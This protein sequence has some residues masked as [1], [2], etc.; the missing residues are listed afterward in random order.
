MEVVGFASAVAVI[1][2][3]VEAVKRAGFPARFAAL[4]A[5]A[6]GAGGGAALKP[7]NDLRSKAVIVAGAVALFSGAV[8][9][10]IA[11]VTI[12]LIG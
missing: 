10:I 11:A 8:G 5:V 3:L 12:R 6:I 2:G 9:A 4:L 7:L 1:A